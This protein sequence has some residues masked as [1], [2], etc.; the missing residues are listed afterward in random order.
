[1]RLLVYAPSGGVTAMIFL[2]AFQ[3]GV[4]FAFLSSPF[5][6][7]SCRRPILARMVGTDR[8]DTSHEKGKKTKVV[9]VRK[10]K[11]PAVAVVGAE[12]SP[13]TGTGSDNFIK[14]FFETTEC[15]DYNAPPSLSIIMRS[16]AHVASGPDIRGRFVDHPRIG[17]VLKV[18]HE[19]GKQ[20]PT[21][22][23]PLTPFAAH[24]LGYAFAT[25]VL[26]NYPQGE[27][28]AIALGR[29]PRSHGSILAD[30]FARGAQ[31]VQNTRVMYTG[32]ATTPA[33]L[34]FC[35]Y[36]FSVAPRN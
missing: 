29:D 10:D 15:D 35:R 18:A 26:Q 28:I 5:K 14:T 34:D 24:C 21:D 1:M 27:E 20:P 13:S 25:M 2:L 6:A 30:A 4:G 23:A 33:M 9:A 22:M 31:G 17:S 16:I 32:I 11:Q 36:V 8:V 7:L 19:I 3:I 12:V